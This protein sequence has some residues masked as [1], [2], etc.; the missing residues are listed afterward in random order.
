MPIFNVKPAGETNILIGPLFDHIGVA[1]ILGLDGLD[2]G[3]DV[4]N[5]L[6]ATSKGHW[7]AL[8]WNACGAM[9]TAAACASAAVT[10]S[11][12]RCP[13]LMG[14]RHVIADGTKLRWVV[15]W[16]Q[17]VGLTVLVVNII[18]NCCIIRA[19]SLLRC[20][21]FAVICCIEVLSWAAFALLDVVVCVRTEAERLAM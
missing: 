2:A 12:R 3:W 1:R 17:N 5:E 19:C 20:V 11:S 21:S 13:L 8:M 14:C 10:A 7:R 15:G 6:I 9:A 4:G 18:T 16:G